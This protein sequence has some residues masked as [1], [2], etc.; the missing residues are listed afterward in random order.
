M[1]HAALDGPRAALALNLCRPALCPLPRSCAMLVVALRAP[2][3]RVSMQ[4][5]TRSRAQAE[6]ARRFAADALGVPPDTRHAGRQQRVN[7][8]PLGHPQVIDNPD[9]AGAE[10]PA[11]A[12][13]EAQDEP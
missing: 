2:R 9:M 6:E 12:S 7:G 1:P 13:A 4:Q 3:L 10:G 8:P 5:G 11:D